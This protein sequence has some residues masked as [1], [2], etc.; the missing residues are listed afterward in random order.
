MADRSH[1]LRG[2]ASWDA[3]RPAT[4]RSAQA[5]RKGDAERHREHSHAERGN[6]QPVSVRS[7][8]GW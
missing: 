2:N 6:D 4:Q 3:P 7:V 8:A 5:L 1:A